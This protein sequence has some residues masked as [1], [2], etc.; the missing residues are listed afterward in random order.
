LR[1]DGTLLGR[2]CLAS[3]AATLMEK[4][5]A[6]AKLAETETAVALEVRSAVDLESSFRV[7]PLVTSESSIM[8][9]V[10]PPNWFSACE[11]ENVRLAA[12]PPAP[13][14]DTDAAIVS[15][16]S[17]ASLVAEIVSAPGTL[18]TLSD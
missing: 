12:K 13:E 4:A 5:A 3:E 17:I 15:A 8:A 18:T 7:E 6:P 2:G 11:S 16:L 10:V 1:G 14:T 9:R